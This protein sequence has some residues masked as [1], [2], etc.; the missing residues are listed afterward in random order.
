MRARDSW[1]SLSFSFLFYEKS[2]GGRFAFEDCKV[3]RGTRVTRMEENNGK[4]SA[5]PDCWTPRS[6][7]KF[8][9][10]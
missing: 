2:K 10:N 6:W 8:T 5:A 7:N 1:A 4:L 3:R 9:F